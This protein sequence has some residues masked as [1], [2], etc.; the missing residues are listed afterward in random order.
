MSERNRIATP[1]GIFDAYVAHPA[2]ASAPVVIV[3]QE[4]FGINADM[5][6]TCDTLAAQGFMAICP[7]LFWRQE[8]GVEL[9]D[10]T[11]AEMSK[12]F[13]LYSAFNVDSGVKDIAATMDVARMMAGSNGRVGVLG[14]CL[15]GLLSYLT[16]TRHA[17]DAAVAYYGGGIDQHLQEAAA[18][19]TPLLLHLA[20]E[21]EYIHKDAQRLITQALQPKPQAETHSYAGCNHAF[22]RHRGTH[23]NA[24]AAE[25]ANA[26]S[27][28][29]LLAH[30][31]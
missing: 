3:I 12:A 20:E 14:F 24:V 17:P 31:G 11:D 4:I 27:L 26:R 16:A 15:G 21:D 10:Q 25:L 1:D 13:A 6:E 2:A 22:A 28:R 29:F 30:L 23:F 5:R 9:S 8:R 7:D 19:Q 18:L